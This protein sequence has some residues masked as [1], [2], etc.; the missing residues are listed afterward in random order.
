RFTCHGSHLLQSMASYESSFYGEG[1]TLMP[2]PLST[3]A[4]SD[5]PAVI[6]VRLT[7]A[8]SLTNYEG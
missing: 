3:S 4:S 8:R 5:C 1:Y 2:A 6:R 7:E